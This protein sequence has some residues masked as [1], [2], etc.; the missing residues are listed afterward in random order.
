MLEV[1]LLIRT[2]DEEFEE[3]LERSMTVGRSYDA[4]LFINDDGMSRIHSSIFFDGEKVWVTDENSTNG[5]YVNGQQVT[6]VNGIYLRDGDKIEVGNHTTIQVIFHTGK[7]K[8]NGYEDGYESVYKE[9]NTASQRPKSKI[10]A[11]TEQTKT[12]STKR[13]AQEPQT[14]FT[15]M[16]LIILSSVLFVV[17]GIIGAV[18]FFKARSSGGATIAQAD[19]GKGVSDPILNS[20]IPDLPLEDEFDVPEQEISTDDEQVV[21]DEDWKTAL[22]KA[23][24]P[25]G[26]EATGLSAA[27]AINIPAELR[28]KP[29]FLAIQAATAIE[30]GLR[31]P[32]DYSELALLIKD[33]QYV[34]LKPVGK[35]NSYVIYAVGGGANE[36]AFKHYFIDKGR[37]VPLFRNMNEYQA[38]IQSAE[39]RE[40][41]E[42]FYK[43]PQ[44]FSLATQEFDFLNQLAQGFNN[45]KFDLSV[46]TQRKFFRRK[47]LTMLRPTT[48]AFLEELGTIYRAR[49]N[50]PLAV[51][52]LV[53]TLEYQTELSKRNTAAAKNDIP[54]HTTGCAIDLSYKYM[55]AE[56]Q[57]FLMNEI[58]K[59]EKAG[60]VEA[61]RENNN[62]YH[63]F[64]FPKGHPP[65][66]SSIKRKGG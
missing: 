22:K 50:R 23:T 42:Q 65:S 51:S 54:P 59:F 43:S 7:S 46:G 9:S 55:T 40:L 57:N 32:H 10:V 11:N 48:L 30:D 45:I 8:D 60:R 63:I 18:V 21:S 41:A 39:N 37:S 52:S 3:P 25:R 64:V 19:R 15:P 4:S 24:E 13:P 38:G 6:N 5:T 53:R 29:G 28:S 36:E 26:G 1:T 49:F 2:K 12:Q 56:E 16:F 58:S 61:L 31:I 34:E 14:I 47:M 44:G 62:C 27:G 35:N 33:G 66:Q 20:D 17:V